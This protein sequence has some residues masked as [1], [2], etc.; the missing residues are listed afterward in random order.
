MVDIKVK[1]A[2]TK[3]NSL[4]HN[5]TDVVEIAK[6]YGNVRISSDG[7]V[8]I[9]LSNKDLIDRFENAFD[10]YSLALVDNRQ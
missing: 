3:K 6:L 7:V 9:T 2:K 5:T 10:E 4:G 1:A 8:E